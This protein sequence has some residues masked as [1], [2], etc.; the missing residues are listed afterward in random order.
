MRSLF[1][2]VSGDAD[3]AFANLQCPVHVVSAIWLRFSKDG[4]VLVNNAV[5]TKAAF[6]RKL[7]PR[8]L[9]GLPD[10]TVAR[11]GAAV[12]FEDQRV[13][14]AWALSTIVMGWSGM[15]DFG[16]AFRFGKASYVGLFHFAGMLDEYLNRPR[17]RGDLPLQRGLQLQPFFD[18][19]RT[20]Y[21]RRVL[22][23]L[24]ADAVQCERFCQERLEAAL[25]V[26]LQPI[27]MR[28]KPHQLPARCCWA[29]SSGWR[30]L[31]TLW[32]PR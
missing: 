29:T 9:A 25:S 2:L 5:A 30:R 18:W 26:H 27:V 19:A 10:S 28:T 24:A 12:N 1:I 15:R 6:L 16:T 3:S 11:S 21:S 17:G 14:L 22:G 31:W 4:K 8:A 7:F 13:A 23:R 32:S 20:N